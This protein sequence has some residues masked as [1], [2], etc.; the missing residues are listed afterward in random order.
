MPQN[1]QY[2]LGF[3]QI[4]HLHGLLFE[5]LCHQYTEQELYQLLKAGETWDYWPKD[6]MMQISFAHNPQ[7]E[8]KMIQLN[9]KCYLLYYSH[10]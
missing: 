10:R 4:R 8:G 7:G 5:A 1:T 3:K 6:V 9:E 2:R